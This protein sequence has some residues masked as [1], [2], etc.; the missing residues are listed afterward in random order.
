MLTMEVTGRGKTLAQHP[1]T[2]RKLAQAAPE[3]LTSQIDLAPRT[4][5]SDLTLKEFLQLN[6]DNTLASSHFEGGNSSRWAT[7]LK[8][9]LILHA[10]WDET[11]PQN[12]L[13][14]AIHLLSQL[15]DNRII[16]ATSPQTV[17]ELSR[18][19]KTTIEN[20]SVGEELALP[21][22]YVTDKGGHAVIYLIKRT[23]LRYFTFSVINTGDGT[24]F[25]AKTLSGI[26][27]KIAPKMTFTG[28]R[29][30]HLSD[31]FLFSLFYNLSN[32][33]KETFSEDS[34]YLLIF[35]G[36]ENSRRLTDYSL[37][38]FIT[39]QHSGTCALKAPLALLYDILGKKSYKRMVYFIT[40]ESIKLAL[41]GKF[42]KDFSEITQSAS[43]ARQFT[44]NAA[45]NL[46][47][48]AT[49]GT[50]RYDFG[51]DWCL[52]A[53][54]VS[55]QLLAHISRIEKEQEEFFLTHTTVVK[56]PDLHAS[57]KISPSRFTNKDVSPSKE[58]HRNFPL[59]D[60]SKFT[61][62]ADLNVAKIMSTL[63]ECHGN[64]PLLKAQ[65]EMFFLNI[66]LPN[67]GDGKR[68][69]SIPHAGRAQELITF[70]SDVLNQYS[71]K[72]G[73]PQVSAKERN[74]IHSLYIYI[75][76]LCSK[77][78]P[79][80]GN[81][82]G[83]QDLIDERNPHQLFLSIDDLERWNE[84]SRYEHE[85]LNHP[86]EINWEVSYPTSEPSH[87]PPI[88]QYFHRLYQPHAD[89]I[90]KSQNEFYESLDRSSGST[91]ERPRNANPRHY[92]FL[93]AF[94]KFDTYSEDKMLI[95]PIFRAVQK[96]NFHLYCLEKKEPHRS[97]SHM[98][99]TV[100]EKKAKIRIRNLS[101]DL[102]R[103][104]LNELTLADQKL[105]RC[106]RRA[107]F[108]TF[109]EIE[110]TDRSVVH[111]ISPTSETLSNLFFRHTLGNDLLR[112]I[113]LLDHGTRFFAQFSEPEVRSKF[114]HHFF[115][116]P[117]S[118]RERSIRMS[119]LPLQEEL[120][121]P[122]FQNQCIKFLE[123]HRKTILHNINESN[124]EMALF[125]IRF[126]SQILSYSYRY[127][128]PKEFQTLL[129]QHINEFFK[130]IHLEKLPLESQSLV[131]LHAA[132]YEATLLKINEANPVNMIVSWCRIHIHAL[133]LE[134][135]REL[136]FLY[137]FVHHEVLPHLFPLITQVE[138]QGRQPEISFALFG[139]RQVHC[140]RKNLTLTFTKGKTATQ[141]A[142]ICLS[143]GEIRSFDGKIYTSISLKS[144]LAQSFYPVVFKDKI[145]S[146]KQDVESLLITDA[147]NNTYR[148]SRGSKKD[149]LI[150]EKLIDDRWCTY[151]PQDKLH[152]IYSITINE[153]QIESPIIP[154]STIIT[155]HAWSVD[156]SF[157]QFTDKTTG[158]KKYLQTRDG[159]ENTFGHQVK[160][161]DP[162][163]TIG[164]IEDPTF[165]H[166]E[167]N[168]NG[169]SVLRLPRF[170]N[171]SFFQKG[172]RWHLTQDK[173][174]F[175]ST[176]ITI[177][178]ISPYYD[179]IELESETGQQAII[180]PD[181]P[182]VRDKKTKDLRLD[183]LRVS[184]ED[185]PIE[186]GTTDH[187]IIPTENGS[188]KPATRDQFAVCCL[189]SIAMS[190][191]SQALY[192]ISH[193][194]SL[195]LTNSTCRKTLRK[196]ALF[197]CANSKPPEGIALGLKALFLLEKNPKELKEIRD[198][199]KSLLEK[200]YFRYT[201]MLPNIPLEYR[202]TE[203]QE[204]YIL[205]LLQSDRGSSDHQRSVRRIN[206]LYE[207]AQKVQQ[208]QTFAFE[209]TPD[210]LST[211]F[212]TSDA[213]PYF[214]PN[215]NSPTPIESEDLTF[216][217]FQMLLFSWK[218][219]LGTLY[220]TCM[221]A[222]QN[223]A[224]REKVDSMLT[225]SCI[226][227]S[228]VRSIGIFLLK[229]LNSTNYDFPW[230]YQPE[231]LPYSF[232][233]STPQEDEERGFKTW[234]DNLSHNHRFYW[235]TETTIS[236]ELPRR[237]SAEIPADS[238]LT[239]VA[240]LHPQSPYVNSV[241]T[242]LTIECAM[243][244][245]PPSSTKALLEL[246]EFITDSCTLA[247]LYPHEEHHFK[248]FSSVVTVEDS[249]MQACVRSTTDDFLASYERMLE[250]RREKRTPS[251]SMNDLASIQSKHSELASFGKIEISRLKEELLNLANYCP[252]DLKLGIE[253]ELLRLGSIKPDLTIDN[254]VLLF[255]GKEPNGYKNANKFLSQDQIQTIFN[256][257]GQYLKYCVELDQ[258]ER[259][260]NKSSELEREMKRL[261]LSHTNQ[262]VNKQNVVIHPTIIELLSQ[263][264]EISSQNSNYDIT[265]DPER[266]IFEYTM[267]IMLRTTP[268]QAKTLQFILR[269]L[270]EDRN[271][272]IG[273]NMGGGK[274]TVVA[275]YILA[276]MTGSNTIPILIT[277]A[278]Q[279][280][281]ICETL[282]NS[283]KTAF[284]VELVTFSN[285]RNDLTLDRL[286][287]TLALLQELQTSP[288]YLTPK[289]LVI[290]PDTI[291]TLGLE[292]T[293]LLGTL[294]TLDEYDV[295]KELFLKLEL[296]KQILIL[297]KNHGIA[298][299]D[300]VHS[301]LDI[302]FELNFPNG[303]AKK[304]DRKNRTLINEIMK[305]L[306]MDEIKA[307]LH[308]DTNTQQK[309]FDHQVYREQVLP[310][311]ANLLSQLDILGLNEA[312]D[313]VNLI[314]YIKDE[315]NF[316]AQL[317][318]SQ[319]RPN[320][321]VDLR[322][323]YNFLIK[324]KELSTSLDPEEKKSA[325]LIA[326]SKF[327]LSNLLPFVLNNKTE[328]E[329]FGRSRDPNAPGEVVPYICLD[330]PSINK[331][332]NP[333]E[334]L[335]FHYLTAMISGVKEEQI[336]YLFAQYEEEAAWYI[337]YRHLPYEETPSVK[338]CR[339]L[340]G[341]SPS[342]YEE[343]KLLIREMIE[344]NTTL[345]FTVEDRTIDRYVQYHPQRLNANAM[346][347]VS[348]V[349]NFI[350]MSGT[351][352]AC[353]LHH[354]LQ[355]EEQEH[356]DKTVNPAVV[357][358]LVSK[359]EPIKF[360]KSTTT[361][362]MIG[363]ILDQNRDATGL[364][365]LGSHLND[366][367]NDTVAREILQ[368]LETRGIDSVVYYTR[369]N[370][371][372]TADFPA[373]LK[374]GEEKP[375]LISDLTPNELK[376]YGLVA[377][378]FFLFLDKR[379]CTGIDAPALP[380]AT[381]AILWSINISLDDGS[382][383]IMRLRNFLNGQKS[384]ILI[385]EFETTL[386]P[387]IQ[388]GTPF[389]ALNLKG[390]Y[391]SLVKQML[392]KQAETIARKKL[393]SFRKMLSNAC[394]VAVRK[395][396]L[397]ME[398]TR[399]NFNTINQLVASI[400]HLLFIDSED[401][402]FAAF[403]SL[404]KPFDI[405]ELLKHEQDVIYK[406]FAQ[407]INAQ[408]LPHA[409]LDEVRSEHQAIISLA[410]ETRDQFPQRV[411]K[412]VSRLDEIATDD[413]T[414]IEA[415]LQ[416]FDEDQMSEIEVNQ[417]IE[418]ELMSMQSRFPEHDRPPEEF[419]ASAFLN[420]QN[421]NFRHPETSIP[422]TEVF[423]NQYFPNPG[424]KAEYGRI[425]SSNLTMTE[426]HVS[427]YSE[428]TAL[429][430][431]SMPPSKYLLVIRNAE[432]GSHKGVIVSQRQAMALKLEI[433]ANPSKY[434]NFWLVLPCG[435]MHAGNQEQFNSEET[436]LAQL[437]LELN[438]LSG[439]LDYA[440]E[441]LSKH[442]NWLSK[443]S[444]LLEIKERF[445]QLIYLK[446]FPLLSEQ[447][448]RLSKIRE[449]E[450]LLERDFQ[451]KVFTGLGN[452]TPDVVS[453][454]T[455]EQ[456]YFV[457]Y[458][459][460]VEHLDA[461]P[462]ELRQFITP[463]QI[464]LLSFEDAL[465]L[466]PK[467]R[468]FVQNL[469]APYIQRLKKR[470]VTKT[471]VDH[472]TR[473]Q[474]KDI[475]DPQIFSL[476]EKTMYKYLNPKMT[477]DLPPCSG[478]ISYLTDEQVTNCSS[479]Q[480]VSWVKDPKAKDR[481][482]KIT[483]PKDLSL[484]IKAGFTDLKDEQIAAIS[485]DSLFNELPDSF[486]ANLPKTKIMSLKSP[487]LIGRLKANQASYVNPEMIQHLSTAATYGIVDRKRFQKLTPYQLRQVKTEQIELGTPAQKIAYLIL[488]F[489]YAFFSSLIFIP[490]ELAYWST[491]VIGY[492]FFD[493]MHQFV[494][495]N[496][497]NLVGLIVYT[498]KR[499]FCCTPGKF[500]IE[501]DPTYS[502]KAIRII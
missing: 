278:F 179:Y 163:S 362:D 325:E 110:P 405:I 461:L 127:A 338:I 255:F 397:E 438:L 147:T 188:F 76:F 440:L 353:L 476:L 487:A 49:K 434:Q 50:D 288:S 279:Y 209:D 83:T 502:N 80:L 317:L 320:V 47:S 53:A 352:T 480:L 5:L 355:G 41:S 51:D 220:A 16:S 79:E 492:H 35:K 275:T 273:M 156:D 105:Q 460:Q 146:V 366:I 359:Q 136:S 208:T 1:E 153:S 248:G 343:N 252:L 135:H 126:T 469:P 189:I 410:I 202:I 261:G 88:L 309:M 182:F 33:K 138:S 199:Y 408:G 166:M 176:K 308:I 307:L 65:I 100:H 117:L 120:R 244:S 289:V 10:L 89:N 349:R 367:D 69:W 283:L 347:T 30:E 161:L 264:K 77:V 195:D 455:I 174:F 247:A 250:G 419:N 198:E 92:D 42:D 388:K 149:V 285:H 426:E 131:H 284:G 58:H 114:E 454:W 107:D 381:Y 213:I 86:Y 265:A 142:Q 470:D 390:Q 418:N 226:L 57:S 154:L 298:L 140:E 123:L 241:S 451:F 465:E 225:I 473:Q 427:P 333:Y 277:P 266:L 228:D 400:S 482:Q 178:N 323:D 119:N 422:M 386:F 15:E 175:L 290:C 238:H 321:P 384:R 306:N 399:R 129:K 467:G 258:L 26:K 27:T 118:H 34:L 256:L 336:A 430:S 40:S 311:I 18:E 330:T 102:H 478:L 471:F 19:Y 428:K 109:V 61:T 499:I 271:A 334:S 217:H 90:T 453:A 177:G 132:F 457:C 448:L 234:L 44:K 267:Q 429:F 37:S 312:E 416:V 172:T 196:L 260:V 191:F 104:Q 442:M 464:H 395:R 322:D 239:P 46:A 29:L 369:H 420:E 165:V 294:Q 364:L 398:F 458:L 253:E 97:N 496:L 452:V 254:L 130:H 171:L 491:K 280:P 31:T 162:G 133:R 358:A 340:F 270:Q 193:I 211:T 387:S 66:P 249:E 354:S 205:S 160:R 286:Q 215:Q 101:Q 486:I 389:S 402:P 242:P 218:S 484:L 276:K 493:S 39:G 139:T 56:S 368:S 207:K 348:L 38:D 449:V 17:H 328:N 173:T 98:D 210:L 67:T 431:R 28:V 489:A 235:E 115:K 295:P 72:A 94:T 185:E 377:G 444:S 68:F 297:F 450:K 319:D 329:N 346:D 292:F 269:N 474:L 463:E 316:E 22:G 181:V 12:E 494:T 257:T 237:F 417:E 403:G 313:Q 303:E 245:Q 350:G 378:K 495:G 155:C 498:S 204:R 32:C 263:L 111:V 48:K 236:F 414:E 164:S 500:P 318:L 14:R 212:P 394:I 99:L 216:E 93:D 310:V 116:S 221:H 423:S 81:F 229:V 374:R 70:L 361:R 272:T 180:I 200:Q 7:V 375:H 415:I 304:L 436:S 412:A 183:L 150:L 331:F 439:N 43:E 446:F 360:L 383:G 385:P 128:C 233:K 365:D 64:N 74:T 479:K 357:H 170:K 75:H 55:R 293:N 201:E 370:G 345:L 169:I 380:L 447:H 396:L 337:Q 95:S 433:E 206:F 157:I 485:D 251:L 282:R 87:F 23:D 62:Q 301:I 401:R 232:M 8:D 141:Q 96:A 314:R 262:A 425:F 407:K 497:K 443:D 468:R 184:S 54:D 223:P 324:L 299:G 219:K 421:L 158:E 382:Q 435:Q 137:E 268:D 45:R 124:V 159:L 404:E 274:T 6:C 376:K 483:N 411:L 227:S 341:I 393:K 432:L 488:T 302:T 187:Y 21:G 363:E 121:T 168:E 24:R 230:E 332:G 296:L 327:I 113:D 477:K 122:I 490:V 203:Q 85:F 108:K 231:R 145:F 335:I 281:T 52:I 466:C 462:E 84:I 243:D 287:E 82:F 20:L 144:L 441:H 305:V 73:F 148:V 472:M 351:P 326:L 424:Y 240:L 197:A 475:T 413:E 259:L 152:K 456:K 300:E 224:Y 186:I 481:L 194:T 372:A 11:A 13:D 501:K 459:N 134:T 222:K 409:L 246:K 356:I 4:R 60:T 190:N 392:I 3:A 59:L 342:E 112:P 2:G 406:K 373:I 192:Y 371:S 143:N 214:R 445:I 106:F 437:L 71:Q 36:L 151:I 379:H 291:Q 9:I 103:L 91:W 339:D 391:L 78:D 315:M 25:H 63:Y 125:S 344:A 167:I